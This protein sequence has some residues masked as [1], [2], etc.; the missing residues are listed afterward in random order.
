MSSSILNSLNQRHL[1]TK[2]KEEY[3]KKAIAASKNKKVV[4]YVDM[5]NPTWIDSKS[6]VYN[7][8][9]LISELD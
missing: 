1:I 6:F 8:E 4:D 2:T 7:L 9:K 5:P 3:I